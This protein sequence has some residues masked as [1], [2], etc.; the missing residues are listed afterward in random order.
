MPT[1]LK[2]YLGANAISLTGAW[3]QYVAIYWLAYELSPSATT[4]GLLSFIYGIPMLLF[5]LVGGTLS[6]RFSRR[7]LLFLIQ[8]LSGTLALSLSAI[9]YYKPS[10]EM[11]FLFSAIFGILFSLENPLK[12][13]LLPN[14]LAN[15]AQ[16]SKAISWNMIM[17]HI[18]RMTGPFICSFFLLKN[19]IYIAFGVYGASILISALIIYF[20]KIDDNANLNK[21][22]KALSL[23]KEGLSYVFERKLL[24]YSIATTSIFGFFVGPYTSQIPN[25]VKNFYPNNI[26][27][28]TLVYISTG[29]GGLFSALILRHIRCSERFPQAYFIGFTL[30][31]IALML[32][33]YG[34]SL[35][36]GICMFFLIT[37][38]MML[39]TGI[40]MIYIQNQTAEQF[41]GR[42]MGFYH[43]LFFGLTPISNGLFGF[44]C[45]R[46]GAQNAFVLAAMISLAAIFIFFSYHLRFG[47]IVAES[48]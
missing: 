4:L 6:D 40:G 14:L 13:T 45:E 8:I 22:R 17:N 44:V 23:F 31:A 5:S 36:S 30:S 35:Y 38:G 34:E 37:M 9:I 41:R 29:V 48:N 24:F 47:K 7:K 42:V 32:L 12:Q 18:A 33:F 2:F 15:K 3:V 10:I 26:E 46:I 39:S 20:L 16:L 1:N 43:L 11:V 28:I 27:M 25:L 21:E 19:K